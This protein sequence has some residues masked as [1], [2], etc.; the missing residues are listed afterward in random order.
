[1]K[2]LAW[3]ILILMTASFACTLA[4]GNTSEE[5]VVR[6]VLASDRPAVI[7]IAPKNGSRYALGTEI[8]IYA[9]AGDLETGVARIEVFENFDTPV[10]KIETAT[11]QEKL[12]GTVRWKP[13]I[14]QTYLI[15]VQA[16]RAD[17][18]PSSPQEISIEVVAAENISVVNPVVNATEAVTE[19]T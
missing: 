18:T 19:E 12:A 16:F 1:M 13:T 14:P 2:R 7:L 17:D 5:S 9:E 3:L 10:G 6:P 4:V 11:P 15:R 8:L